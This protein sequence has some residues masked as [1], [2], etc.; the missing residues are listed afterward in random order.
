[1]R[2]RTRENRCGHAKPDGSCCRAR[3]RPGKRY[4]TFHDPELA[5]R[6]AE[7][8]RRGG[9]HRNPRAAVLPSDAP[10]LPLRTVADILAAVEATFNQVRR[11][12]LDARIGNCLG[13][14]AQV[15]LK[16]TE[17]SELERR[18]AVLEAKQPQ[19]RRPA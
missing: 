13:V 14:L 4:C 8:R 7:G 9:L 3:P 19:L 11:G 10:D 15:Q 1:M 16:A 18:V 6:R 2:T 12:Q 5:E 17:G